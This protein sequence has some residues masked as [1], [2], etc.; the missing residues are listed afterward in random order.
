M[1]QGLTLAE[2]EEIPRLAPEPRLQQLKQWRRY[3]QVRLR[4]TSWR[5]MMGNEAE[6]LA[7]LRLEM[8][9]EELTKRIEALEAQLLR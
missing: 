1:K 4:R 2:I 3:L 9:I 6:K 7:H 8:K 5:T